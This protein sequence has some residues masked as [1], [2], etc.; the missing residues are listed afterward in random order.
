MKFLLFALSLI[1]YSFA[2]LSVESE[3]FSATSNTLTYNTYIQL[4][5]ASAS[6]LVLIYFIDESEQS[7]LIVP[8]IDWTPISPISIPRSKRSDGLVEVIIDMSEATLSPNS[9]NLIQL[10]FHPRDWGFMDHSNDP[11]FVGLSSSR[12]LHESIAMYQGGELIYGRE[13]IITPVSSSETLSSS[14]TDELSREVR[15]RSRT[16]SLVE[17]GYNFELEIENT[18]ESTLNNYSLNYY[19][20]WS[21]HIGHLNPIVDWTDIPDLQVNTTES[22]DL[23]EQ[24]AKN[25]LN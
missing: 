11:S 6:G 20:N 4:D 10:R 9:S 23:T 24:F 14:S 21:D 8:I 17:N 16:I 5:S 1:S 3:L 22:S 2:A 7:D 19:L 25:Y 18:G 15:I 12:S 13:P